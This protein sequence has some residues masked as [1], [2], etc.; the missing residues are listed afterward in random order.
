MGQTRVRSLRDV[1]DFEGP[2]DYRRG[3]RLATH[4]RFHRKWSLRGAH[5]KSLARDQFD[6][7]VR[8]CQALPQKVR[9]E[10]NSRPDPQRWPRFPSTDLMLKYHARA[11]SGFEANDATSARGPSI[12]I[13]VKTSTDIMTRCDVT[14]NK[15]KI[16]RTR[17]KN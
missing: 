14:A 9:Y 15:T 16:A 7:F 13:S 4:T 10:R 11:L 12:T 6:Y 5:D 17:Q 3:P 2:C 1:R 8:V